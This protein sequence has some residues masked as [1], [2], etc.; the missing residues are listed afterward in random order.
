MTFVIKRI[1]PTEFSKD[2]SEID[3]SSSSMEELVNAYNTSLQQILDKHAPKTTADNLQ[4]LFLLYLG[5]HFQ[6]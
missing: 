1:N 5:C 3:H 4:P 6:Q 2:L